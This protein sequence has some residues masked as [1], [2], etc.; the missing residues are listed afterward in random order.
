MLD[1]VLTGSVARQRFEPIAAN[2]PKVVE[3]FRSIEHFELSPSSAFDRLEP[4]AALVV[5]ESLGVLVTKASDH[6]ITV[7]RNP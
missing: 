1:A 4:P 2:L 7:Y 6:P 5:E 3:V